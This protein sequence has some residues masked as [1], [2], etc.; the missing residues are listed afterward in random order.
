MFIPKRLI[1]PTPFPVKN[2]PAGV[3]VMWDLNFSVVNVMRDVLEEP[4][5]SS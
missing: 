3:K 1:I 2:E 5:V 4:A